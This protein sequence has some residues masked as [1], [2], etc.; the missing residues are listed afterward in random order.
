MLHSFQ[1]PSKVT[2][3]T[4]TY[5]CMYVYSV[6][7][8]ACIHSFLHVGYYQLLSRLPWAVQDPCYL[9]YIRYQMVCV[10]C[11]HPP[12]LSL[13]LQGFSCG[14]PKFDLEICEFVS[15]L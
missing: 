8:Y 9:S 3:Y 13:P 6:Y 5:I 10:C 11:P 7:T 2:V 12:H 14:K 1:V 15:V 4:Y